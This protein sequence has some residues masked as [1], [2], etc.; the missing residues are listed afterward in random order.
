MLEQIRGMSFASWAIGA[1]AIRNL[2]W[3]ELHGLAVRTPL[4]DI[5][6]VFYDDALNVQEESR[7]LERVQQQLQQVF[8][9]QTWDVVN[10]ASV[11]RWLQQFDQQLVKPFASL[12]EGIA[13]WP[14]TATCVAVYLDAQSHVK[15]IAPHGLMDLFDLKLRHNPTRVSYTTFMKRVREKNFQAKW[16][17]LEVIP[18]I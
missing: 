8:P 15:V 3:D 10:Q 11:H 1:G 14:E 4:Q 17:L 18:G 16:P 13:S 12:E 5:D 7:M 2:V 6:L 9:L